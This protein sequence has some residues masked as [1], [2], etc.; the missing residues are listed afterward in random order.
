MRRI[1]GTAVLAAWISG[2]A[3]GDVL[4]LKDGRKIIGRVQEKTDSFEA[5]VEGQQLVFDKDEVARW[6]RSPKEIIGDSNRLVEEAK[7]LFLEAVE[8]QDAQAADRKFREALPKVIKAREAY[9]EAR[10]LFPDGYSEIDQQLVNIMKLM[11]LIRERVGSE[12]ASGKAVPVAVKEAPPPPPKA[13]PEPAPAPAPAPAPEPPKSSAMADAFAILAD[14][15]RRADAGLRGS[16]REYFRGLWEAKGPLA[17]A[18]AAGYLFLSQDDKDWHLV[19]DSVFIKGAGFESSY[20]GKLVQKTPESSVLLM[21]GRRAVR[22]RKAPD[23]M[24]AVPPGG[25]EF[26]T[27]ACR[28]TADQKSESLEVLQ[29]FFKKLSPET[30]EALPEKEI[31]EG[32][33]F[34]AGKIKELRGKEAEAPVEALSLFAG[35]LASSLVAK[36]GGKAPPAIEAAF[37]DLGYEPSEFGPMWGD[38]AGL[39]LDDFKKWTASAEYDLAV[40]QFR[41]DYSNLNEFGVQYAHGLLRLF[42]AVIDNRYY[43]LVASQF[44][45]MAR[46]AQT[47]ELRE[48]LT[49]LARS[50]RDAAPCMACG[51][52]HEVNC[53]ACKGKKKL[54]LE[55]TACGGSGKVQLIRQGVVSCRGCKGKGR[56]VNVDCPKC[57]ASG[58]AECRARYC[59]R[60]VPAPTFESFAGA[61]RCPVCRGMGSFMRHV[62]CVCPECEGIGMLLQPKADPDKMI[63]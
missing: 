34:L 38:R 30:L 32:V 35:G 27:E 57:K 61:F 26:R 14:P 46:S 24:Y 10:D 22:L 21:R 2:F 18:A 17:D 55:C 53:S 3:A 54:T 58:K 62:A 33:G 29:Q 36:G 4:V 6:V 9:A 63:R 15:A 42:K 60:A 37:K 5:V 51:G 48:H 40:V 41:K 28:V 49:A 7:A 12:I 19:T 45:L 44:E 1:L 16:A 13:A 25:T 39:A 31:L 56:F 52:T 8:M 47:H 59:T 50:I 43:N 11:R 23:G 20:R